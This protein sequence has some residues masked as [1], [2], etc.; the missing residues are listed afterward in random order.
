MQQEKVHS[1]FD[2][3]RYLS[4]VKRNATFSV[5]LEQELNERLRRASD[6]SGVAISAIAR[7]AIPGG[8]RILRRTRFFHDAGEIQILHPFGK[9]SHAVPKGRRGAP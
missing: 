6:E 2:F 1:G 8:N 5:N 3:F 4:R 7:A 9:H